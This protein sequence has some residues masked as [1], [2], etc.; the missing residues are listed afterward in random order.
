MES[1]RVSK[2]MSFQLKYLCNDKGLFIRSASHETELYKSSDSLDAQLPQRKQSQEAHAIMLNKGKQPTHD[3]YDRV[4][5]GGSQGIP[6]Q[7]LKD[8]EIW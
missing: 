8:T 1:E 6:L 4:K 2:E 5:V 3:V 7:P